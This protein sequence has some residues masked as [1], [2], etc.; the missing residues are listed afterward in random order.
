MGRAVRSGL[1]LWSPDRA[2]GASGVAWEGAEARERAPDREDLF[3]PATDQP[4]PGRYSANCFSTPFGSAARPWL[5]PSAT[6]PG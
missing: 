6:T 3:R 2:C 1:W 5:T 4:Y